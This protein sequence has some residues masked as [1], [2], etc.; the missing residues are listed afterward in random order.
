MDGLRNRRI[1]A[2][3]TYDASLAVAELAAEEAARQARS[4]VLLAAASPARPGPPPSP[5]PWLAGLVRRLCLAWPGLAVA[6]TTVTGDLV[7]ALV[8]ASGNAALLVVGQDP[9]GPATR[10]G[11]GAALVAAY[12]ECPTV[13]VPSRPPAPDRP[14]IVGIDASA[15]DQPAIGFALEEAA[16]R[17]V[18]LVAV[19]VWSG[20][21][22]TGLNG[23]SPF[24]YDPGRARAAADRLLAES[25][26]GWSE[27]YPE[28][29]VQRR[30]VYGTQ[31]VAV[32]ADAGTRAGLLVVGGSRPRPSSSLLL[33]P[34]TR[35]LLATAACPIAVVRP[36]C[37]S[38]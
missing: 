29:P 38:L 37:Y 35:A 25:L 5:R 13:V 17:R 22:D 19:R 27:K 32:L 18:P 20:I 31:P 7:D 1:V 3:L 16:L 28:V 9:D 15:A 6:G 8:D 30:A 36:G 23:I 34:V 14:V 24:A 11:A 10:R 21:P 26:A 33:G 12:A 4:L 2:G